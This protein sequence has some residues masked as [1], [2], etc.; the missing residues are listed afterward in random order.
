MC[1]RGNW[2][3]VNVPTKK[4]KKKKSE[5]FSFLSVVQEECTHLTQED[6]DSA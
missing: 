5:T 6:E 2:V 3:I 1:Q 4:K